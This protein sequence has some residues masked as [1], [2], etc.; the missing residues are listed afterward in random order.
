MNNPKT[1]TQ[2]WAPHTHNW[3]NSCSHGCLYCYGRQNALRFGVIK[4]ASEWTQ[5]K[6]KPGREFIRFTKKNGTIMVPSMSD[7]TPYFLPESIRTFRGL[8]AAGNN[9]LI[10]SKPHLECIEKLCISLKQWQSQ[11]LFRF[12]IGTMDDQTAK[13]WE[14]G[15]PSISERIDCLKL[16]LKAGYATS[17]SCEPLLGGHATAVEL[18][19]ALEPMVTDTIWIGKLNQPRRRVDC[20]DR[21]VFERV[22]EIEHMQRDS[23]MLRLY[24]DLRDNQ[25][26]KFKDSIQKIADNLTKL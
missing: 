19:D 17:V 1:G 18:V 7:I 16:A 14:P 12:T 5:E 13:F 21:A 20:A 3:A 26:V 6:I 23:E 10:V 25:K 4:N 22:Q 2:E 11:I 24:D 15:A 8:L 9:L